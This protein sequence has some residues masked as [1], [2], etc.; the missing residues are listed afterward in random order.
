MCKDRYD[1]MLNFR[2]EPDLP[3]A[4]AGNLMA[5]TPQPSSGSGISGSPGTAAA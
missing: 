4:D 5:P 1:N 3:R 2:G